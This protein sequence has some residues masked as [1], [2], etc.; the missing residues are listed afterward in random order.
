M[1]L[2]KPKIE[3][4]D[5]SG[6]EIKGASVNIKSSTPGSDINPE[7][8]KPLVSFSISNPFKKILYWLDQIRKK[9]TTTFAFKV[10]VPLIALPVFIFALV[11]MGKWSGLTFTRF[12]SVAPVASASPTV[13]GSPS[14]APR[15]EVSKAGTLKVAKGSSQTRYLLSLRNGTLVPLEIPESI[16][17]SK[18]TN[19][20]VLVTGLQNKDTGVISVMDIAEVEVFNVTE[21]PK[22]TPVL[23][24]PQAT[25]SAS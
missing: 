12:Q 4:R 18:Y 10:S 9:Q 19:K 16:N 3:V 22:V 21:I 5:E 13:T 11:G 24:P 6:N 23:T 1:A 8:E 14:P 20:Q 7:F 2:L 17:L 25:D 15:L